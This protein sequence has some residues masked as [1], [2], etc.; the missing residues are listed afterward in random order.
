MP[1]TFPKIDVLLATYNGAQY[2]RPQIDSILAQ[3]YPNFRILA[4]D[5]G[6]RDGTPAILREYADRLP[7]K[8]NLLVDCTPT[9]SAKMNFLRLTQ[10]STAPYIAFADQDDVWLPQKLELSMATMQDLEARANPAKP[11][12]VFSDLEVVDEH[13]RTVHPSLWGYMGV[14][15][16]AIHSPRELLIKSVVTGCTALLNRPLAELV[17]RMPATA[18]MHDQWTGLI[19]S[20]FGKAAYLPQATVRYRQHSNNAVG[21]RAKSRGWL[22]KWRDHSERIVVWE[23]CVRKARTLLEV[24]R[25]DM[26]SEVRQLYETVLKCECEPRP[27]RRVALFRRTRL[28]TSDVRSRLS[29]FWYLLDR[30]HAKGSGIR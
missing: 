25:D 15:P 18:Y 29:I 23:E 19:V 7:D 21:A 22:P 28:L 10:A 4:R 8:F 24:H 20:I 14:T 17:S 2:L 9:G 13:L 16:E 11:L 1:K 30:N 6:S 5:D 3:T 12:L 26:P 27:F